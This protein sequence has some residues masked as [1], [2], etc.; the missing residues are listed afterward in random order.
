[1][2]TI[3]VTVFQSFVSRNILNTGVLDE[4]IKKQYRVVLFVPAP[5]LEFYRSQYHHP[6]VFVESLDLESG[7]DSK[8]VFFKNLSELLINTNAIRFRMIKKLENSGEYVKYFFRRLIIVTLGGL[9]LAKR[10]Y[11]FLDLKINNNDV[12][13]SYIERYRP[14]VVF[15]PDVFGFADVLL[16]KSAIKHNIRNVGMVASW[17]NNTTKG[18]MRV[19]PEK[20]LVQNEIIKDESVDIQSVPSSIIEVVGIAHYDYYK[21]YQ[22]LSREEYFKKLGLDPRKRLMMYAPAGDKFISTDWQ[23]CE[24]LKQAYKRGEIP[25][26]VVTL[27]R[28]HP[29]NPVSLKDFI[30]DSHFIIENPGIKFEGLSDKRKE[31]DKDSMNHLLDT[32]VHAELV[33][34]VVSSMVIDAA[35]VNKPVITIGFEGWEKSVPFGSS[36]KRYH[37]DENMA[38]LLALGGTLVVYSAEDLVRQINTY[39][40]N[41]QLGEDGRARIVERQCWKL[42]VQAKFRIAEALSGGY[43]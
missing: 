4:L 43:K 12:F 21:Q 24:M 3:F 19:I 38:K 15:V 10:L 14:E 20:L 37:M 29:T 41:P 23:I 7:L 32:L 6:Q 30:P 25:E 26:D 9:K 42:D 34:N 35:V 31:L 28:I 16:L 8:E 22:P 40:E 36:V 11:R 1:M 39:L 18:L 17:D 2:K 27:I 5:K 13:G 33:I